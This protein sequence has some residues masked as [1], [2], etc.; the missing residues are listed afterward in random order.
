MVTDQQVRRLL[1]LDAQGLPKSLAALKAGLDPKTARKYRRLVRLPSEVPIMERSWRTRPDAFAEVWPEMVERLEFNPDLQRRF[2]GRFQDGQIRALQRRI[3][4]WRAQQ[5]PAR[6]VFFDQV[7]HPGRLCA[8]DF[9]RCG[10]L[11]VT[12]N[13]QPFD[14]LIYHF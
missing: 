14:H 2:P 3:K 13:G 7:H 11:K 12:V 8:S 5:G 9:T 1:R 10:D 4:T 6:E